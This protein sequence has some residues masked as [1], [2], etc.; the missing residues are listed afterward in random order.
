MAPETLPRGIVPPGTYAGGTRSPVVQVY[1]CPPC[2]GY[3]PITDLDYS[4]A[5]SGWC[6]GCGS[7][8]REVHRFPAVIDSAAGCSC[9]KWH[10]R[11]TGDLS[12]T[13]TEQRTDALMRELMEENPDVT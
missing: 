3:A 5:L 6:Q 1:L 10:E 11:V 9:T 8:S 12:V 7:Q 4:G 2:G 13:E